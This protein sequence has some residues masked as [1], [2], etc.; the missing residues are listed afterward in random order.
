MENFNFD[1]E[2][3][4]Q[5]YL[6]ARL[7]GDDEKIKAASDAIDAALSGNPPPEVI[8][9]PA[10]ASDNTETVVTEAG[11]TAGE[12]TSA[13]QIQQQAGSQEDASNTT[14]GVPAPTNNVTTWL[15]SLDPEVRKNVE[16]L[17]NE[18]Q[19]LHH[20]IKSDDGRVAAFQ[21]RYN[22]LQ[23]LA[24]QQKEQLQRLQSNSSQSQPQV[25]A[26]NLKP[27]ASSIE[28]D[29]DL[30]QIAETDPVLA[31][32][33]LKREQM[34]RSQI[35]QLNQ[36]LEAQS[37]EIK[38]FKDQQHDMSV[39]SELGRLQQIIPES[40]DIFKGDPATGVNYWE[41]WV[42]NQPPGVQALANSYYAEEVAQ[43]L[44]L[45]IAD[46]RHYFGFDQQQP[47]QAASNPASQPKA[48]DQN[49]AQL[50]QQERERK[51]SAA[52]VGSTQV[53]PP[54]RTEPTYDELMNN[55]ELLEKFQQAQYEKELKKLGLA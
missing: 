53:R 19:N 20:R 35:D 43:A 54:Q 10:P 3:L 6:D 13:E 47:Q 34:I 49:R 51:L 45:H 28:D 26:A 44:R 55:P 16:Q 25:P 52:P 30:Q 18:N 48:V 8:P 23:K 7:S 15:E 39:Q 31:Q 41:E 4:Q 21:R 40:I 24:V 17:M 2:S 14:D 42:A 9:E 32:T 29:P 37:Q 38:P 1:V 36:R 5:N 46:M 12:D 50:V 11:S 27:Q 22:D 33:I